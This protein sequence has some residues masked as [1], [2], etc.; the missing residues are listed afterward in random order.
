MI[1]IYSL[2]NGKSIPPVWFFSISSALRDA[3]RLF[4]NFQGQ[5]LS[6]K[7]VESQIYLLDGKLKY[8]IDG[9]LLV[10]TFGPVRHLVVSDKLGDGNRVLFADWAK[11]VVCAGL[12][13]SVGHADGG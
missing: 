10:D 9:I 11:L 4:S 2:S 13:V 12:S 7:V 3:E 1:S 6:K 5:I 8:D